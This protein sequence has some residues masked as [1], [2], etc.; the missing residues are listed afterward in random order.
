MLKGK[1]P[2]SA[3]PKTKI[4]NPFEQTSLIKEIKSRQKDFTMNMKSED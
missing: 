4:F 3:V 1:R 2:D